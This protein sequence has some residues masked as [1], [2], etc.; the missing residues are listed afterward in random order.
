M[1]TVHSLKAT[2]VGGGPGGVNEKED[3]W[4][5]KTM[6]H[7]IGHFIGHVLGHILGI[8]KQLLTRYNV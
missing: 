5:S 8:P 6:A 4:C 7:Y 1:H 3:Q 2:C